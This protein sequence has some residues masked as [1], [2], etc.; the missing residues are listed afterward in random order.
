[1]SSPSSLLPI[2]DAK[3]T[4]GPP[5]IY[6]KCSV[7]YSNRNLH[8]RVERQKADCD[9]A[10]GGTPERINDE[11]Q[12]SPALES[13][14]QQCDRTLQRNPHKSPSHR[15]NSRLPHVSTLSIRGNFAT[16]I[17]P[18]VRPLM[19]VRFSD[20][21]TTPNVPNFIGSSIYQ[22]Q[23]RQHQLAHDM[24]C[25][26][27]EQAEEE[28]NEFLFMRQGDVNG[29][30]APLY[31]EYME[32]IEEMI[33]EPAWYERNTEDKGGIDRVYDPETTEQQA[34]CDKKVSGSDFWRPNK[35]Y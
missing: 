26:E 6:P 13:V 2:V 25:E 28:L 7:Q 24:Q 15:R 29:E 31:K 12:T 23:A 1:M 35:L 9:V 33:E 5:N 11:S 16:T 3:V 19:T 4:T 8:M 22:Q 17:Q 30:Y 18:A 27:E 10:G 20:I 32:D 14:L 21:A 34:V